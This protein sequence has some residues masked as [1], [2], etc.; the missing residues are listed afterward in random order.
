MKKAALL[1]LMTFAGCLPGVRGEGE[2][3]VF[4]AYS[5]TASRCAILVQDLGLRTEVLPRA[6]VPYSSNASAAIWVGIHFPFDKAILVIDI[7]R[8][9]YADLRYIALS[10][11][12]WDPVEEMH[13]ELFLGG[14]TEAAVNLCLKAWTEKDF[15]ALKKVKNQVEFQDM[16]KAHYGVCP[17]R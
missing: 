8:R 12:R 7:G 14:S 2:K 9:Y 10:D 13:N 3:R 1:I 4:L 16:I 5:D 6:E 15:D 17:G 11:Y